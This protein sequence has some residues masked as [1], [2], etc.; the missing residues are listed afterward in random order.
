MVTV[1]YNIGNS[2]TLGYNF[3]EKFSAYAKLIS[4]VLIKNRPFNEGSV[5]Y[6]K[7]DADLEGVFNKL[8]EVDFKG[9]LIMQAYRDDE[10]V[11]VFNKQLRYI[12]P[13]SRQSFE[14]YKWWNS[15]ISDLRGI[16]F[17]SQ[18]QVVE[19]ML[20]LRRHF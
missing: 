7:G 2:A 18:G 1:N 11:S 13:I 14:N 6:G 20:V 4:V 9:P 15:R 19:L 8:K 12:E 3:E 16:L 10:G 17:L 5:E